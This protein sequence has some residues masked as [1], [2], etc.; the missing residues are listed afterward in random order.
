MQECVKCGV[1]LVDGLEVSAQGVYQVAISHK[2]RIS[3]SPRSNL[4]ASLCPA[5]GDVS[6]YLDKDAIEVILKDS[7]N[8]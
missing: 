2:K 4:R 6:F 1:G 7:R 3:S 8:K 5:C